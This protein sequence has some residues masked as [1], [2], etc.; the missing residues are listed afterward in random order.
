MLLKTWSED[1]WSNRV[2]G[3]SWTRLQQHGLGAG[4]IPH[5]TYQDSTGGDRGPRAIWLPPFCKWWVLVHWTLGTCSSTPKKLGNLR[6]VPVQPIFTATQT[7]LAACLWNRARHVALTFSNFSQ[8]APHLQSPTI[9]WTDSTEG[10]FLLFN[11]ED[12]H[13]NKNLMHFFSVWYWQR[14]YL[15]VIALLS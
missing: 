3:A 9:W 6:T 2:L 10:A 5:R 8:T 1:S 15:H 4:T 11:P 14:M 12:L 13:W 7:F